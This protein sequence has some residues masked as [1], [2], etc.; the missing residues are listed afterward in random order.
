[1]IF[2]NTRFSTGEINTSN[3]IVMADTKG[4]CYVVASN[5]RLIK[6]IGLFCRI[7]SLYRFLLQKRPMILRS[8]LVESTPSHSRRSDDDDCF[9]CCSRRQSVEL[10]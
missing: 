4:Q 2:S 1:M 7:S 10:K 6:I 5:S 9:C 8:L 3:I